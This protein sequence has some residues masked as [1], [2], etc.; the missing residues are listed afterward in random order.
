MR[1]RVAAWS[2]VMFLLMAGVAGA[3]PLTP[4][5]ELV[6]T[7]TN[8]TDGDVIVYTSTITNPEAPVTIP[9][10]ISWDYVMPDGTAGSAVRAATVTVE[11]AMT[12]NPVVAISPGAAYVMGSA[13]LDNIIVPVTINV[14]PATGMTTV[15]GP[16]A[17]VVARAS[18][19]FEW[20]VLVGGE[21]AVAT[22]SGGAIIAPP[23]LPT[24]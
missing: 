14:D 4:L 10:A 18:S 12:V 21:G 9:I 3:Q 24:F 1:H 2:L 8:A 11:Y 15:S 6:P 20:S 16:T 22:P 7:E 13:K 5:V 17:Q 23:P 19:V